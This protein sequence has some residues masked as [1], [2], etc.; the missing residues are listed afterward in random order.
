MVF[1]FKLLNTFLFRINNSLPCQ[2]LTPGPP[3]EKQMT[4]QYATVLLSKFKNILAKIKGVRFDTLRK[5]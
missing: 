1:K 4:Y 3:G 5:L 2:D